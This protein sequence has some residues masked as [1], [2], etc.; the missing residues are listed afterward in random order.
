MSAKC[1]SGKLFLTKKHKQ[2]NYV[3]QLS[4]YG[5]RV[6]CELTQVNQQV[7]HSMVPAHIRLGW[8]SLPGANTP[9][10]YK[11]S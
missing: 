11:N 8:K 6:Q 10:Y 4:V 5:A 2:V 3:N 7:L 9:A 1:Q